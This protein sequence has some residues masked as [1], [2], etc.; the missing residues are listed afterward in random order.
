M[1][2]Q[3]LPRHP[4]QIRQLGGITRRLPQRQQNPSPGGIRQRTPEPRQHLPVRQRLHP[5]NSTASDVFTGACTDSSR[6]ATPAY[7]GS[8]RLFLIGLLREEPSRC[9]RRAGRWLKSRSTSPS[10]SPTAHSPRTTG[11]CVVNSPKH[12]S[13]DA[14]QPPPTPAPRRTSVVRRLK[15][16]II[17]LAAPYTVDDRSRRRDQP[18]STKVGQIP[19]G[20][21]RPRPLTGRRSGPVSR[22]RK[23][24]RGA[25]MASVWLLRLRVAALPRSN[26]TRSPR[27]AGAADDDAKDAVNGKVT[28]VS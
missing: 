10:T 2:G 13:N 4:Q 20:L 11:N 24:D 26:W 7:A 28:P 14:P 22:L 18:R 6:T 12:S 1:I 16:V 9:T 3:A 15:T 17:A 23:A 5:S 27:P 25:R 8:T 21:T 19:L